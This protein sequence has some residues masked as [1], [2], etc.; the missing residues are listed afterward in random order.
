VN[1]RFLLGRVNCLALVILHV[2]P[3][4]WNSRD[5]NINNNNSWRISSI[6]G[7]TDIR[8]IMFSSSINQ[9][10]NHQQQ[11]FHCSSS[12]FGPEFV[13][14]YWDRFCYEQVVGDK[15][16]PSLLFW[17]INL[18]SLVRMKRPS[19]DCFGAVSDDNVKDWPKTWQFLHLQHHN[20][21]LALFCF[22]DLLDASAGLVNDY[23]C[24]H[25]THDNKDT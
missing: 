14:P 4:S 22:H 23:K 12:Y 2:G 5:N 11:S 10:I 19:P 7:P 9:P 3:H 15:V 16:D 17:P 13:S 8:L 18:I 21:V 1:H 20:I 25:P 24:Q 6:N